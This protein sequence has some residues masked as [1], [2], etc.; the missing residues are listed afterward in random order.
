[1]S[2]TR[3]L[4]EKKAKRSCDYINILS[5]KLERSLGNRSK[6]EKFW[7]SEIAAVNNSNVIIPCEQCKQAMMPKFTDWQNGK[8]T[9][10][11]KW[12][13]D[14]QVIIDLK[15][16]CANIKPILME[17]YDIFLDGSGCKTDSIIIKQKR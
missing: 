17:G 2:K 8:F 15:V 5:R 10:V 14:K 16:M 7:E 9:R 12:C 6:K 3:I 11:C 4:N 1:M 13:R